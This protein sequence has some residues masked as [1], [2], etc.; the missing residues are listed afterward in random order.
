MVMLTFCF[1]SPVSSV[2][3]MSLPSTPIVNRSKIGDTLTVVDEDPVHEK[4][5]SKKSKSDKD[6]TSDLYRY[7][8]LQISLLTSNL[9]LNF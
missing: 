1:V 2:S 5:K 8:F 4:D 6:S 7:I 9:K 3:D